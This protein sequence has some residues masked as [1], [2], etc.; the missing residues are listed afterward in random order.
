[1]SHYALAP[2]FV[3]ISYV[4][5][6]PVIKNIDFAKEFSKVCLHDAELVRVS[7]AA[8]KK[9]SQRRSGLLHTMEGRQDHMRAKLSQ[10]SPMRHV[11]GFDVS[12]RQT[13]HEQDRGLSTTYFCW[14]SVRLYWRPMHAGLIAVCWLTRSLMQALL[15][16]VNACMRMYACTIGVTQQS[17]EKF[18]YQ[19]KF[20][21][22]N[23][24]SDLDQV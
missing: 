5:H 1:M 4:E 14:E 23:V 11:L 12:H 16:S 10:G 17:V 22:S 24:Y 3:I 8:K 18:R 20:A 6:A 2:L 9:T 21:Q 13:Q 19:F 15:L 7:K